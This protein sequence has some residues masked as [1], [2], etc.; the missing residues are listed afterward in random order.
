MCLIAFAI[1]ASER[2]PLIVASNRD[3]FFDRPTLSLARWQTASGQEMISGRDVRAGGTWL[4]MTP[5]GR[6][7]F[8]TNVR[9]A[10][11]PAAPNSR[12]DLVTRWLES[13]E[14]AE[15][16]ASTLAHSSSDYGGFNLVLGDFE[17]NAWAWVTNRSAKTSFSL[18][19]QHLKPGIYGLS[20][21]ALDTPWPKTMALKRV[22]SSALRLEAEGVTTQE[23]LQASLWDALADGR[24][25]AV[26]DL[27]V[28]GVSA[29]VEEALSSAFVAFPEQAYG[30]RSSTLLL[31]ALKGSGF[32]HDILI[33]EKTYSA[34]SAG[35][36]HPS[37]A[38]S[39]QL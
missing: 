27:P 26:E 24:R 34:S 20:N 8:L 12:G 32:G 22:L 13:A 37:E 31:A 25:A 35:K 36:V 14:D 28:T 30:T 11:M 7:A 33:S 6:I 38:V 21:A 9:E 16:F 2:W 18:D 29:V 1:G 23:A 5:A 19:I 17:K 10:S 3:E 15:S 39:F 4:G